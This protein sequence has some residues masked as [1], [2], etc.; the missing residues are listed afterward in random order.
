MS[1][2]SP[3]IFFSLNNNHKLIFK[4]QILKYK[5]FIGLWG[6]KILYHVFIKNHMNFTHKANLLWISAPI[7]FYIINFPMCCFK[8]LPTVNL[9]W[10]THVRVINLVDSYRIFIDSQKYSYHAYY[11]GRR[12]HVHRVHLSNLFKILTFDWY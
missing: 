12:Y 1:F 3:L 6:T 4:E 11:C 10:V 2:C 7:G 8:N 5:H 9:N